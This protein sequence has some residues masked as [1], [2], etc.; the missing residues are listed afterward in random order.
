LGKTF[1]IPGVL[2]LVLIITPLSI[3][4]PDKTTPATQNSQGWLAV[5]VLA[6]GI[7]L[8]IIIKLFFWDYLN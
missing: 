8:F 7:I 4:A 1:T 5:G 3:A 2:L 6:A